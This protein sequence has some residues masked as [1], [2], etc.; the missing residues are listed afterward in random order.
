MDWT[1]D[2]GTITQTSNN[3]VYFSSTSA[4]SFRVIGRGRNKNKPVDTTTVVVIEPTYSIV[5]IAVSPDPASVIAGLVTDVH[6]IRP[7]ERRLERIAGGVLERHG[8]YHLVRVACTP[9]AEPRAAFS[10]TAVSTENLSDV[11]AVSVTPAP[12]QGPNEPDWFHADLRNDLQLAARHGWRNARSASGRGLYRGGDTHDD[13]LLRRYVSHRSA[14]GI[15]RT[16]MADG[17]GLR[18]G[19]WGMV[20][21]G[22]LRH[23]MR[24]CIS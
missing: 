10:V 3:E 11:A 1:A 12:L 19:A 24:D 13:A 23:G 21:L 14:S 17:P 5:S 20:V 18:D 9:R 4:G 7:P 16:K 6:G 22:Q 8:W 2:G 15:L